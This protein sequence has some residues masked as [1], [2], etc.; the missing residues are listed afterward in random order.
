MSTVRTR[1]APSPTGD[2][3]IGSLRT[4]LYA[5]AFAKKNNGK[6]I[7]RIEDTD[8]KRLVEGSADRALKIFKDFGLVYDEGPDV[9]GDYGP[10]IQTERLDIYQKYIK[11]LLDKDLAYYCFCTEER[12]TE[13]REIQKAAKKVPKYDRHCLNL[14][15]AEIQENLKKGIP[16]VIRMKIPDNETIIFNDLI[17]GQIKFNTNDIDDQVLIKS[18]GIPT[19]HFAVVVD[20]HLMKISHVIRAEEWISS[21]PKHILLYRFFGWE[22]PQIAHLTVLLDPTHSGKMSKR[23]GSVFAQQFLDDGY[24][25]DA[26]LNFLMLLGWNSGTDQELFTLDEFIKEFSVE[27][28][29]KKAAIFD[30]KKLDYFNGLYIRQKSNEELFPYFRKF[31]P[32]ASDEQ[33]KILIPV[34]KDRLIKFSDLPDLTKFI[35]EDINYDKELLLKKGTSPELAIEMLTKTKEL[36][37]DFTNLVSRIQNLVS[38]NAWNTGEFF[39]V[40]R[41]AICGSAFTPPVVECLPALGKEGTLRK[42]DIALQK[43]K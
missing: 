24:L 7:V 33:I 5:Y 13:M 43:L 18:N 28:L 10:Y 42:I 29:H 38:T 15:P 14:S 1:M 22:V 11:E 3:H 25:P 2:I 26:I 4:A 17:R 34:L 41:V 19:Y 6:F 20:D 37:S 12:L 39:M 40:L 21:T 32:A 30:R 23:H 8:Q 31:L 36:L 16:Y 27:H 9:G 35:F